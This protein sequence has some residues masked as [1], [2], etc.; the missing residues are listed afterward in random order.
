MLYQ[1]QFY[2]LTFA[3]GFDQ[4]CF[5]EECEDKDGTPSGTCASGYGV[6]CICELTYLS[7]ISFTLSATI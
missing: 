1:V 5:R 3:S 2:Y 6:C 7:R 4:F